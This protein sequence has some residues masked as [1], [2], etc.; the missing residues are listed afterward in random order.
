M[1]K[2]K[3]GNF[4]RI[5]DI[6]KGKAINKRTRLENIISMNTG[7]TLYIEREILPRYNGF[8]KAHREDHARMVIKQ[9]LEI[10]RYYAVNIE[11]VYAIAAFHDLGL[12]I[13]RKTHHLESGRIVR[14]DQRLHEWFTQE[15]IETMAQAVEDH[16][17]SSDHEPR[18]IYGKIVAEGDRYI[19]P[20]KII[21]RTIQYGLD[22]YPE[23]DKE[24][25]WQRTLDHLHEK[26]AEGGYLKLWVPESP[27]VERLNSLREIIKDESQ[28]RRIFDKIWL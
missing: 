7:L 3:I 4:A 25:H 9:S 11:M 18:S 23:L 5:T 16:R 27:N 19:E 21:E 24:G 28:L 8:D 13:D 15:E 12:A 2:E 14:K 1:N 22:H 26:Y 17:A 10:A 6:D 20:E